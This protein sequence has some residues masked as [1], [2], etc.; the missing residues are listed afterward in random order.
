MSTAYRDI[1]ALSVN[2]N[3]YAAANS[4]SVAWENKKFNPV[5]GTKYIRETLLPA[6]TVQAELGT[7]G[8]DETLGIY[9]VDIF[10]PTDSDLGKSEAINIADGVADQ[11]IRGSSLTYNGV[12]VRI[13]NVSRGSG[14]VDGAWFIVPIFISFR[15]Y[16][17]A[18]T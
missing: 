4:I 1:S 14:T 5:T 15:S 18:R 13:R 11:F 9:Q 2:L 16:T 17:T 3:V 12:N 10:A 8:M 6:D 7:T